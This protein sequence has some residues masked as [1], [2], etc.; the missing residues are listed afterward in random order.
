MNLETLDWCDESLKIF[1]IPRLTLPKILSSSD[2]FG[3]VVNH[4]DINEII[5]SG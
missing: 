2:N 5:I 3:K 1:D 4:S